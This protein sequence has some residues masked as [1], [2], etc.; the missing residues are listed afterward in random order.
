M[1]GA[2]VKPSPL[3]SCKFAEGILWKVSESVYL[4]FG[5]LLQ[6]LTATWTGLLNIQDVDTVHYF[7]VL[8]VCNLVIRCWKSCFAFVVNDVTVNLYSSPSSLTTLL[9]TSG[10]LLTRS[11]GSHTSGVAAASIKYDMYLST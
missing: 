5:F 7:S 11:S 4:G 1:Y 2:I 3:P 6:S 9:S 8:R 10:P